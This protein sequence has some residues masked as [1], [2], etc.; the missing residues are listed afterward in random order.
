MRLMNRIFS[1]LQPGESA[2]LKRLIT[3]DDLF[4]FAACSGNYNPLHLA[5]AKWSQPQAHA[6]SQE[7]QQRVAP[8]LFVASLISAVLGTQLP[9][10]GTLYRRQHLA[11]H[12]RAHAGDE[13][14]CR[15]K[16]LEKQSDG[17]VLL[18]TTVH[19]LADNA[20]IVSGE[21]LVSAPSEHIEA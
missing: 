14:V 16:V 6:P 7:T 12:E 19:R 1:E 15:V 11:F 3:T 13:L 8:G 5:D 2:E 9:G 20:L 17:L 18:H 4:A 21:A 10:A